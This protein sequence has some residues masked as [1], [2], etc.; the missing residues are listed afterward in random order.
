MC[1]RVEPREIYAPDVMCDYHA[2]GLTGTEYIPVHVF[3]R[4]ESFDAAVEHGLL[5]DEYPNFFAQGLLEGNILLSPLLPGNEP[6]KIKQAAYDKLT[7]DFKRHYDE[8]IRVD[9]YKI[10]P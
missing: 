8:L 9:A 3:I 6:V 5:R 10:I 4:R 2:L 1:D 7:P